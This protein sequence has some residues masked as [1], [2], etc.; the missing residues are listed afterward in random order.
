MFI[1]I[2]SLGGCSSKE[3]SQPIQNDVVGT[4]SAIQDEDYNIYEFHNDGTGLLRDS[5]NDYY[6]D[7]LPF[8]YSFV[9]DN[10]IEFSAQKDYSIFVDLSMP[11]Q[12]Q[13][14]WNADVRGGYHIDFDKITDCEQESL[15]ECLLGRWMYYSPDGDRVVYAFH[16]SVESSAFSFDNESSTIFTFEVIDADSILYAAENEEPITVNVIMHN[17]YKITL[18]FLDGESEPIIIYRL[19]D[20]WTFDENT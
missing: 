6:Y 3:D 7:A 14:T 12:N 17:N 1:V 8:T 10:R 20:Y 9:E 19:D 15:R 4:W 11:S 5:S 18:A 2:F 16:D 13:L